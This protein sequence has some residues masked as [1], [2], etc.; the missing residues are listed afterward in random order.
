MSSAEYVELRAHSWYSF[1]NGA[2]S[3]DE[4]LARTAEL[5]M[6]ALGVTDVN[7]L[8]GALEFARAATALGIQPISGADLLL[9]EDGD[10][11]PVSLLAES[12]AGYA[13][14]SRLLSLAHL[15]GGRRTPMADATLAPEHAAGLILLAGAP[16]SRLARLVDRREW[17]ESEATLRRYLDWFGGG[18]VYLEL[19]QHL[20]WG[21]T[22]RIRRLG[23]LAERCGV[24]AVATNEAWYHRRGRA[25]LH[26]A[27]TAIRH[28][29][30]LS[31]VQR[32][33]KTNHQYWLKSGESM[34]ALFRSTPEALRNSLAIAER[35]SDF[36]LSD[37]M[38]DRYRFPDCPVPDGHDA[39]SWF[40]ELC[41]QA[42]RRRYDRIDRRVRD[43]LD[44]EF[45]LIRHHGLAG[46]F[47]IYHRVVQLA[48]EVMLEL[49]HG[50]SEMPLEWQPPGRGR[51]SSVV[52]LTGYLIGLSHVDPLAYDLSLDRFLPEDMSSTPDID[53]DF[54][55]D[56]REGLILRLIEEWGWDHAALTGMF[57][58]YKSRGVI[59]DLGKALGLPA[60]ETGLLAKQVES[61]SASSLGDELAQLPAY[62]GKLE[63]PGWRDLAELSGQLAGFPKGLAQHPGGMVISSVPLTDMVPV[64]PSAIAGRYVCQWDKDSVDDASFVKIDLLALG[65]LSQMQEAAQL[66]TKRTGTEP[67]LSRID[68][69]DP[70]VYADLS[71][72]DTV[73]VF[74]VES[75]AQMQTIPRMQPKDIY[76]LALEVAA[77]RP[78]VGANDGVAEFLRRR[79]GAPWDYDHPLEKPALERSLGVIMFQD[80]VVRLGMDVGGLSAREAD[81]L[82]R[83]FSRRNNEELVQRYWEKFRD[84]A[85]AQGADEATARRIYGKFNPHYMFPEGHALAF[86]FTAFQMAWLRHYYPLE[87]FVG[88][89]NQQ[90]MGFWDLETLKEDARRLN[91]RVLHPDVNRS[92]AR[93]T[94][95][96]A[97]ALRLGLTSVKGVD[98]RLAERLLFARQAGEFASL[99]DLVSRSG[100]QREPLE[101]L[102]R[103]GALDA[104]T[105]GMDRRRALWEVGLTYR[106]AGGGQLALPVS[107][108]D[109]T[110][111]LEPQGR[112]DRMLD[113]YE[114]LGLCPD[115]QVMELIRPYLG[116]G[117][118]PAEGLRAY[119]DGDIVR[120]AG[121]V[122][123][124]QR[125]LA[126]AVFMTLEDETG[127]IPLA[128]WPAEWERLKG[129]L[130]HRLVLVEGQV[131]RRDDTLNIT[132]Q[133]AWPLGWP[134]S[135]L[136]EP[137]S[138]R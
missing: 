26:D 21:D 132:V 10:P 130:G 126:K 7:N 74:Q 128:V 47:L 49:G 71:R 82:R 67:D 28:N 114:M 96:G 123:R 116:R 93:C 22:T 48:R 38:V 33:L 91:L 20:V 87:F 120:V 86:A 58:T 62:R 5:E 136:P 97:D 46:F 31:E 12:G 57:A 36:N 113:E 15:S 129:A 111:T 54:P 112:A 90:P 44:E 133:G 41:R 42:A 37:Y 52:M 101:R 110:P 92:D 75:A 117:V 50:D 3:V 131:S 61:R 11:A 55:R 88:L 68:F 27:L 13:N 121:R 2:S 84:G 40:E 29:Q 122:V 65:A 76:D 72:G 124:R 98:S 135:S 19:Q 100:L 25:R 77:V 9:D 78:G 119:R 137:R 8:C 80:Q 51:G 94:A 34:Q 102:V 79:H 107:F 106:P 64:Q 6:P 73:G 39:Q 30:S 108:D 109:A 24:E 127:L 60:G 104:V 18:S 99:G 17:A 70:E 4:L 59:R 118:V 89:F 63:R 81:Q 43:R 23:E 125:P 66:I 69:D 83:A 138:W 103:A 1:L 53:L 134:S 35:C 45:A 16:G 14:L 95:E 85:M 32:L 56:I 115:G 105:G